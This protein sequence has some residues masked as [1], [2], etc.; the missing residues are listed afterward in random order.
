[1]LTYKTSFL[2]FL[3]LFTCGCRMLSLQS[4]AVLEAPMFKFL[5]PES[6]PSTVNVYQEIE[7]FSEDTHYQLN[8]AVRLNKDVLQL[9]T[10]N[11][12]GQRLFTLKLTSNGLAIEQA[13]LKDKQINEN[14]VLRDVQWLF[15]PINILNSKVKDTGWF[16]KQTGNIRKV[17]HDGQLIATMRG[18]FQMSWEG[19]FEYQNHVNRYRLNVKSIHLE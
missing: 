19:E 6:L 7:I 9:T 5:S 14:H 2:V 15:W 4:T 17:Y 11:T 1:M 10:M 18:P 12:L 13:H 8:A 16:F 3:I